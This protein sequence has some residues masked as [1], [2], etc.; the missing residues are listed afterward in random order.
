MLRHLSGFPGEKDTAWASSRMSQRRDTRGLRRRG[1]AP[2]D[3]KYGGHHKRYRAEHEPWLVADSPGHA[4]RYAPMRV[5]HTIDSF[6]TEVSDRVRSLVGLRFTSLDRAS[7]A[8]TDEDIR[9][10]PR[11]ALDWST[12]Q[13]RTHVAGSA[14]SNPEP[15][16]R[17]RGAVSASQGVLVQHQSGLRVDPHQEPAISPGGGEHDSRYLRA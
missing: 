16:P 9:R 3:A 12:V 14:E 10:V 6:F 1:S 4:R 5:S 7:A 17:E 8:R 11:Q 2:S 13:R 15:R